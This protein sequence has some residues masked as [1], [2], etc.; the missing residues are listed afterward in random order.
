[1]GLPVGQGPGLFPATV[2]SFTAEL[3]RAFIEQ[4]GVPEIL[5]DCHASGTE[6]IDELGPEHIRT[7]KPISTR[8][9][10]LV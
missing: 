3:T 8:P 7:G 9:R 1:M 10:I 4:T 6:I 2:P 5:G